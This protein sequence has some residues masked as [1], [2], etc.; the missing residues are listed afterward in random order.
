M[1]I[2]MRTA[3]RG[4]LLAVFLGAVAAIAAACGSSNA[5]TT[6]NPS[7]SSTPSV[8]P[9]SAIKSN[10]QKFFDGSTPAAQKIQLLQNGQQFA[11]TIQAQAQ[12]PL[13]KSTAAKVTSVKLTSATTATVKYSILLAKQVALADQTGQAVLQ[14]GVWKVSANSFQA[15]LALEGA[16][17]SSPSASP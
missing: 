16:A 10:W 15:L 7:T 8:S 6:S 1:S 3:V 12:S 4:A 17:S 9:A 14:N 5:A 13:A 2:S 11:Q